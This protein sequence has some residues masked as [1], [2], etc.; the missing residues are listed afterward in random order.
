M[1]GNKEQRGKTTRRPVAQT[2]GMNKAAAMG[3]EM[4]SRAGSLLHAGIA[5]VENYGGPA[6]L[7]QRGAAAQGW[8]VAGGGGGGAF[9]ARRTKFHVSF[10][11][12][13]QNQI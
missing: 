8:H 4:G 11:R 2:D 13:E 3:R 9:M 10:Q 1:S 6:A 5:G 7:H 12:E